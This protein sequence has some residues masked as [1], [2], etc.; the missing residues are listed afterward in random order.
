MHSLALFPLARLDSSLIFFFFFHQKDARALRQFLL[1]A[2][3]CLFASR[4]SIDSPP[5]YPSRHAQIETVVGFVPR[6]IF[7][8]HEWIM[9]FSL[10]LFRFFFF[11]WS[12]FIHLGGRAPLT[13]LNLVFVASSGHLHNGGVFDSWLEIPEFLMDAFPSL[14]V[15]YAGSRMRRT[16]CFFPEAAADGRLPGVSDLTPIE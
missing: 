16:F 5:F 11:F 1:I 6:D 14:C 13:A 7:V 8:L 12:L 9:L 15:R 4:I 3:I 2:F 10:F